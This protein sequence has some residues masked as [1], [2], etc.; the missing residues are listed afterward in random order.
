MQYR[1]TLGL[2][3]LSDIQKKVQSLQ[4]LW[5]FNIQVNISAMVMDYEREMAVSTGCTRSSK[6]FCNKTAFHLKW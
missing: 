3:P 6:W 2:A 4:F 1:T 5:V